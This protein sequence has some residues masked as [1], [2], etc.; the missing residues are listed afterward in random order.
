MRKSSS[1]AC[2]IVAGAVALPL[3]LVVGSASGVPDDG[4]AGATDIT[5]AGRTAGGVMAAAVTCPAGTTVSAGVAD[6]GR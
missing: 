3:P 1:V 2:G 6:R 4:G 5:S